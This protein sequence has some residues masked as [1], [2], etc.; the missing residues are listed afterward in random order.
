MTRAPVR[1]VDSDDD[2][3]VYGNRWAG[4]ICY[5]LSVIWGMPQ[6]RSR[7]AMRLDVSQRA[8]PIA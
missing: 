4:V 2:V 6:D 3:R 1:L 5:P 7:R 8:P